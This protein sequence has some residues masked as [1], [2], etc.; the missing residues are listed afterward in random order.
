MGFPR[1]DKKELAQI[2]LHSMLCI[3]DSNANKR[4]EIQE[5]A[6]DEMD[7]TPSGKKPESVQKTPSG[8]P[9]KIVQK[10][11]SGKQAESVQKTPSDKKSESVQKFP[12]GK[13][14]ARVLK[15]PSGKEAESVQKTKDRAGSESS[16]ESF[17]TGTPRRRVDIRRGKS[18]GREASKHRYSSEE[19]EDSRGVE[20]SEEETEIVDE[21]SFDDFN[22]SIDKIDSPGYVMKSLKD[23]SFKKIYF[24]GHEVHLQQMLLCC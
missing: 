15:T 6:G 16:E 1:L 2:N 11:P 21:E 23:F 13:Q 18:I 10:T 9:V 22:G 4:S 7:R 14:A 17:C 20:N 24:Q 3:T 19:G 8:K 5:K 12:S